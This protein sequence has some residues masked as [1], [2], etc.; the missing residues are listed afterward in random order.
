ME[1]GFGMRLNNKK[2]SAVR[3][4]EVGV[5]PSS[6]GGKTRLQFRRFHDS[7]MNYGLFLGKKKSDSGDTKLKKTREIAIC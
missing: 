6:K 3:M 2:A 5:F 7:R 1:C 4:A